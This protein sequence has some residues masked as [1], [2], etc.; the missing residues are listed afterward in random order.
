MSSFIAYIFFLP[1]VYFSQE[2]IAFLAHL[3]ALFHCLLAFLVADVRSA[4]CPTIFSLVVFI[5]LHAFPVLQG[6]AHQCIW[7]GFAFVHLAQNFICVCSI[8]EY[9]LY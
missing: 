5:I 6:C 3:K 2:V 7:V 4:V 9:Y 8:Y 1:F